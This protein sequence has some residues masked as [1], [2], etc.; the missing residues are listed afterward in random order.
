MKIMLDAGHGFDT[1]GK[2]SPNGMKEYEFNRAVANYAKQMLEDY[3]NVTVYFAHSDEGDVPLQER[4][5]R[6]NALNVDCYI[7]IHCNAFGNGDWNEVDGI[8]TYVYITKPKEAYELATVIHKQL[9][10]VT[11][12]NDRGVKTANFHVLRETKMTAVLVECGFMTNRLEAD[13]LKSD[14]YRKACAEGIVR[15]LADYYHLKK[16]PK[17]VPRKL[18]TTPEKNRGLYRVQVGAFKYKEN[19]E[20]LAQRLKEAGFDSYIY[21]ED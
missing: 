15:G 10:A 3:E 18:S 11:G 4:T 14:E 9:L 13:L 20:Q 21:Y 5:D 1:P 2:R 8:E 6:A 7:S 17:L 12:R 19:A 16:K